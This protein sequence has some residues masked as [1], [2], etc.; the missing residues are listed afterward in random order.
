MKKRHITYVKINL[1][2]LMLLALSFLS[3]TFAWF[4]YSGLSNVS[5][6]I[7]VKAWY[8][9]LKKDGENVSNNLSISFSD[10]YPG[11]KPI[12]ETVTIK[13]LGDSVANVSYDIISARILGDPKD[14]YIVDYTS[15]TTPMVEDLLAHNYPFK[16][17]ISLN[18]DILQAGNDET[19]F[20]VSISWPMDSEN[21]ENDSYWGNKAYEFSKEENNKLLLDSSYQLKPSIQIVIKLSAEQYLEDENSLDVKY[22]F[23][24]FILYD[25]VENKKCTH[26][27]NNCIKTYVIDDYNEVGDTTVTLLPDPLNE[28]GISNF[29]NYENVFN[30]IVATWNVNTRSLTASDVLKIISKDIFESKLIRENLSDSII[31]T[32][33]NSDRINSELEK[34]IKYNGLYTFSNSNFKF[35]KSSSCFWTNTEYNGNLGFSVSK[36]D[37]SY[38]K[39]YGLSKDNECRIIPVIIANKKDLSN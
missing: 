8:I 30:Q 6:E 14:N 4:G 10:L 18:K 16:I 22:Q 33:N 37:E 19:S 38:S 29:Y 31:G 5:T 23:G 3:L 9:E 12:S 24:N 32:L 11:M 17:N 25:I 35:L 39:L 13:N 1:F 21:D 2:T 7:D 15:V 27:T 34:V 26:L 36:I 20:N 28:Y